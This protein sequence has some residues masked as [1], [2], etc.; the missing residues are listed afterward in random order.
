MKALQRL[1]T[2]YFLT[3]YLGFVTMWVPRPC[4]LLWPEPQHS[5]VANCWPHS[6]PQPQH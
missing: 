3:G 6:R 5:S 2:L 4:V 1:N